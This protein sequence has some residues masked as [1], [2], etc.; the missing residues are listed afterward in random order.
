MRALVEQCRIGAIWSCRWATDARGAT[1]HD[2]SSDVR[3]RSDL[4][5]NPGSWYAV[6]LCGLVVCSGR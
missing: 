4:L 2:G 6:G 1:S 5:L 3:E